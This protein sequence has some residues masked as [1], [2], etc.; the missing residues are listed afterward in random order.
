LALVVGERDKSCFGV[1]AEDAPYGR[2]ATGRPDNGVE[3]LKE[4]G[5][6]RSTDAWKA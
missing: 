2:G 3:V 5:A 1:E 6:R 4:I